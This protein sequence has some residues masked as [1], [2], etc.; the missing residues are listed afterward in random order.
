MNI[1]YQSDLSCSFRQILRAALGLVV[2][3]C[4]LCGFAYSSI[5][6]GL[7]QLLFPQQAN[8]SL[9]VLHDRVV[10]SS[11]VAQPFL[12][13]QYFQ[14]RPSASGYDPMAMAGSNMA[15]TSPELQQVITTRLAHRAQ[16][17]QVALSEIPADLV[18]ASGKRYRS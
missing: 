12:Q 18:T 6:T 9:I 14:P 2:V 13:A 4:G 3:V 1:Q 15:R 11:L 17:E 16:L 5:A 8:G 7:G 10:G